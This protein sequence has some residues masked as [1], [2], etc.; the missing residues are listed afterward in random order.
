MK[1]TSIQEINPK[2]GKPYY[3]KDSPAAVKARDARRMYVNG[4]K[5]QRHIRYMLPEDL[6]PLK[7][8]LSQRLTST[9]TLSR[10]MFI[11]F[12]ILLGMSG[13]R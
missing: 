3:Y 12:L 10:A 7:A 11:L 1:L 5:F 13:T 9:Q 8:Q 4:K 2:T 6:K